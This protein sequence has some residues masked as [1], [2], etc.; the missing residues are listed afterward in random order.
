VIPK[1]AYL[2]V[3]SLAIIGAGVFF[4]RSTSQNAESIQV[5]KT[6]DSSLLQSQEIKVDIS[7]SVVHS[8][9]YEVPA[10]SRV[11][12]VLAEAG[13]LTS[14]ADTG[15]IDSNLNRAQVVVD[16]QKIFIPAQGVLG[17]QTS[18]K[19][20]NEKIVINSATQSEL[21]SLP[22]IG[23]V[24]AK[25]IIDNRPYTTLEELVSKKV[26]GQSVYTKIADLVS[27]W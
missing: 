17:T 18:V 20:S 1:A 13:G 7:G 25:K 8:G 23:A 4:L 14:E 5:V 11:I 19:S 10:G 2:L 24:T 9:V 21:E 16:G 12:D 6:E 27:L 3:A 26:I 22:Q 15:W